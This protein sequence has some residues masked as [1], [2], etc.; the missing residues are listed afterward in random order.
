MF[1]QN[2]C[3]LLHTHTSNRWKIQLLWVLCFVLFFMFLRHGSTVQLRLSSISLCSLV[4]SGMQGPPASVWGWRCVP[5]QPVSSFQ[6]WRSRIYWFFSLYGS[7]SWCQAKDFTQ[8]LY[9]K[10]FSS[11]NSQVML[12]YTLR[13]A[14]TCGRPGGFTHLPVH[15]QP[16]QVH[17]YSR[18]RAS[19]GVR[20][21]KAVGRRRRVPGWDRTLYFGDFRL[22]FM[23]ESAFGA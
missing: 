3:T 20:S 19:L 2:S 18:R 22:S 16:R 8:W 6:F 13:E 4:C 11:F 15:V 14:R 23:M 12:G 9:S 21:A 7:H 5:P 1:F 10:A 17:S